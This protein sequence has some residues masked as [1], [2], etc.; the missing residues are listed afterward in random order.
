[1]APSTGWA[2]PTDWSDRVPAWMRRTFLGIGMWQVVGILLLIFIALLIQR[3]VFFLVTSHGRRAV[4]KA[5]TRLDQALQYSAAPLSGLSMALVFAVGFPLLGFSEQLD[6]I[7]RLAVR[8]LAVASGVLLFYRQIDVI[9]AV[10]A[11]KAAKTDTL[12]DD[13]LVPLARRTVKVFVIVIGGIFVL[14][15]LNVDV[16]SLVAG[17]GLGGLAFALAAKDTVA[18]LFGSLVIFVDRP[19][20][21]GDWI[22]VEDVEGMVEDVGFRTT[23]IRTLYNSLVT[24]PNGKL[25]GSAIDNLG[26]RKYR[27]I[28]LTLGLTYSTSPEQM[29]AFVEGARAIVAAHPDTRKDFY[30]VHF[31]NFGA[32]SLDVL[33]YAFAAVTSWG[34]ELRVRHELL[35]SLLKLAQ[36]VGVEYAFPTRTVHVDSFPDKNPREVGRRLSRDDMCA[37]VTGYAP[38]GAQAN[39]RFAIAESRREDA[40]SD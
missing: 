10:L 19:F 30:E 15:N 33:F 37:V 38:G 27:R 13:Q 29:Q 25:T 8:V 7:V 6:V 28:K 9:A 39:P 16:A 40:P 21:L 11:E 24:M 1:M 14:Q 17:L 26:M 32:F 31:N 23:R 36:D 34:E 4:G 2:R 22:R 35:L 20:Q 18:N 3:I 5:S 12:L